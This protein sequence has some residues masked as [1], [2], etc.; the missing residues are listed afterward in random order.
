MLWASAGPG[1][2]NRAARTSFFNILGS[3][4]G[5]LVFAGGKPPGCVETK[6]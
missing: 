2:R 1:A 6:I 3:L 4:H 5:G